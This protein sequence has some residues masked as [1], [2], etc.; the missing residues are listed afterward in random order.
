MAK[1]GI[2]KIVF[3]QSGEVFEVYAKGIY[4]SDLYGFVE[5]SDYL[6]DQHSQILVDPGEEKLKSE[7]RGVIKSYIPINAILRID[8][9]DKKGNSKITTNKGGSVTQLASHVIDKSP[10]RRD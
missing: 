1:K 6:F 9:V 2:Y 10:K 5:V 8:E 4:Q 3:I 7:F